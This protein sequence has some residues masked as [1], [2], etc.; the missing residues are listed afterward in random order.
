MGFA[1]PGC[2]L[3]ALRGSCQSPRRPEMNAD[4]ETVSSLTAGGGVGT[5]VWGSA[6]AGIR[7]G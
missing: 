2:W 6:E 4:L 7:L 5:G 1:G 3:H